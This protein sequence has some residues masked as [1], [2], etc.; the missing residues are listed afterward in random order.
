M[1]RTF[2]I[3][4]AVFA[5][6]SPIHQAGGWSEEKGF[7]Y[8]DRAIQEEEK[9]LYE[10]YAQKLDEIGISR[11]VLQ[12]EP[13]RLWDIWNCITFFIPSNKT[14]LTSVLSK[15]LDNHYEP[16]PFEEPVFSVGVTLPKMYPCGTL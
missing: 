5:I 2:A 12:F 11:E 1:P 16:A 3:A 15:Y 7:D 13:Y 6:F 9:E 4:L 8:L 10:E 14:N